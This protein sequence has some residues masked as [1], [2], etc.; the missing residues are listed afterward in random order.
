M[1]NEKSQAQKQLTF[2]RLKLP[3]QQ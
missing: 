3:R 2:K 1:S